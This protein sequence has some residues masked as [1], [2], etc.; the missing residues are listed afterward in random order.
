MSDESETDVFSPAEGRAMPTAP[1]PEAVG[2]TARLVI[3]E[4]H[5][6]GRQWTLG[7]RS[8]I[9][10]GGR[11]DVTI[12]DTLV[13]REHAVVSRDEGGWLIRDLGSR[14][15]THVNGRRIDVARLLYGD[16]I[17][18]GHTVVLLAHVDPMHERLLERQKIEALGRLGAGIAHD[19]N[20]YFGA[21]LGA[22][23]FIDGSASDAKV[24]D[25][26]VRECLEDVRA[27]TKRGAELT[28]RLLAFARRGG[29]EHEAID[30]ARLC[31][32]A[33]ELARRTF[34]RSVRTELAITPSLTVR[35]DRSRLHQ[36][37]MNLLVNARDA[38]PQGGTIQVRTELLPAQPGDKPGE[39]ATPMVQITIEDTGTGIDEAT[40]DR[41][42]EPFFTTKP[43]DRGTG[44]GLAITLDV[45]A[46]H[47][48]S[49]ECQ[50]ELGRGTTFTILLPA[51]EQVTVR[52]DVR[53]PHE[54]PL[55]T[56]PR[57]GAVLVVDDEPMVR[58]TVRR[59]LER[60]GYRVVEAPDGRHAMDTVSARPADIAVVLMDLD[61][62]ELDGESACI[63][64]RAQA[65][66][67]PVVIL[68]GLCDEIRRKRLEEA[69]AHTVL[70]KPCDAATL[71]R[72]IHAAMEMRT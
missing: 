5:H 11:S 45:I 36:V 57:S 64:L 41:M 24:S 32:E 4:G 9:G 21:I 49:I 55:R 18:L 30:V 62:P 72:A 40:R 51:S 13:S 33:I 19:L 54:A 68:S 10:R 71:R 61:M 42:F 7:T 53:T 1:P 43:P 20:N 15:G 58:R 6:Q 17:S 60:D 47:G 46:A 22:L 67:L 69:G 34:D 59:L 39:V 16:R 65:P 44:L 28:H 23:E 14:N 25:A 26:D 37:L 52:R 70:Q 56:A 29:A 63:Q 27:A 3:L 35:G 2:A 8:T 48:G 38:M 66:G 12:E 31:G 50:S